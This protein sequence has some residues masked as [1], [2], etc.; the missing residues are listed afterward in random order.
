MMKVTHHF[1]HYFTI[2][3]MV[4][5]QFADQ[6]VETN[7][8]LCL[9][10]FEKDNVLL[11]IPCDHIGCVGCSNEWENHCDDADMDY[12]CGICRTIIQKTMPLPRL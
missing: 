8:P 4:N 1:L 10:E 3:Q 12:T 11:Y 7:C 2:L 6:M 5:L 9:E